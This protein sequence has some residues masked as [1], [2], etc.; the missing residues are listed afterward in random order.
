MAPKAAV[1]V[2]TS[3][4]AS[5]LDVGSLE[6]A[7]GKRTI[8]VH[9]FKLQQV[10]RFLYISQALWELTVVPSTSSQPNT[11]VCDKVQM[12]PCNLL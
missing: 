8:E 1:P 10:S 4:Q 5:G 11:C 7:N 6:F 12:T 2:L 3:T 9:W